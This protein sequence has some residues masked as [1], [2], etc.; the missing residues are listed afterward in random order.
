MPP[1]ARLSVSNSGRQCV[2]LREMGVETERSREECHLAVLL[3]ETKTLT[4]TSRW[5]VCSPHSA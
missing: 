2:V 1:C 5:E 3:L 4:V